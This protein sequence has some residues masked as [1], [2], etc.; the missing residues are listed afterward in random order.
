MGP[1]AELTTSAT[2]IRSVARLRDLRFT[3]R[4]MAIVLS[5][6]A[7]SKTHVEHAQTDVRQQ[8]P[9]GVHG[10]RSD[11]DGLDGSPEDFE[12]QRSG[13]SNWPASGEHDQQCDKGQIQ[14]AE[15]QGGAAERGDQIRPCD[16][17]KLGTPTAT[18]N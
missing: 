17:T 6:H 12:T 4:I 2:R 3:T 16:V 9:D 5:R 11:V 14:D 1:S 7:A 18:V 10:D 13:S 15:G 8:D